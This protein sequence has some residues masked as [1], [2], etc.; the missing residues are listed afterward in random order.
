MARRVVTWV[1]KMQEV[2]Q[3]DRIG[4]IKF[5][6]RVEIVVPAGMDLRV[7]VGDR[8]RAGE[9]VLGVLPPPPE[10]SPRR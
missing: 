4:M 10:G 6:S 1:R 5:G 8:V 3:G 7:K 9:T 2:V